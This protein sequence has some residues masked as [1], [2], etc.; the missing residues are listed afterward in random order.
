M[1]EEE[2]YKVKGVVYGGIGYVIIYVV[3]DNIIFI[4]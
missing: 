2:L 3:N 4:N 1:R